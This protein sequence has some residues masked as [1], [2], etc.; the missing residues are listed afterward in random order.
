MAFDITNLRKVYQSPGF[1][2]YVYTS[3]DDSWATIVTAGYFNNTDDDLNLAAG[4]RLEI[5]ASDTEGVV[6][7]SAVS[8]G[9]VTV[10]TVSTPAVIEA[11]TGTSSATTSIPV[12]GFVTVSPV[13]AADAFQLEGAPVPGEKLD[14]VNISAT[15]SAIAL[16]LGATTSTVVFEYG[17]MSGGN[18][19]QIKYGG[20]VSLLGVSATEMRIMGIP[21]LQSA[22][23]LTQ[24]VTSS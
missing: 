20:G 15:T 2:G 12:K 21:M 18:A 11:L 23:S 4:D 22:S 16:V 5:K 13:A 14:I 7:V 6:K 1:D 3:S 8:S 24:N 19:L 17:V 10:E 9:S